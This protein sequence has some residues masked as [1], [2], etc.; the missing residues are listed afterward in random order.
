MSQLSLE[1]M[2]AA[3][4]IMPE[5]AAVYEKMEQSFQNFVHGGNQQLYLGNYMVYSK[6]IMEIKQVE[7]D[8]A[9]ARERIEQMKIHMREK[10]VTIRKIT[11][12]QRLDRKSVV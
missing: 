4:G 12:V 1:E 2:L 10:D 11:E 5:M 7:S 6:G 8:L 9:R 3:F